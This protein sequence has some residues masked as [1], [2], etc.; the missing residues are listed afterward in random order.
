LSVDAVQ[1]RLICEEEVAVAITPA[2]TEG[3]VVSVV[4]LFTVTVTFELVEVCPEASLAIARSVCA[5]LLA[6]AVFHEK[7]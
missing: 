3:G 1:E 4:E 5:P 6:V 2:G 7:L